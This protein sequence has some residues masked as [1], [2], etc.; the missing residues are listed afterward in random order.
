MI[1]KYLISLLIRLLDSSMIVDYKKINM[2]AFE[3]WAYRSFDDA[4]WKSYFAYEELKILKTLGIPQPD[5]Q[6]WMMIGKRQ[7]L[8]H[9]ADEMRKVVELKKSVEE[10][11]RSEAAK[12]ENAG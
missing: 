6:Y 12:K 1:K 9:L 3:E 5:Y 10:K 7:Q 2:K 4:G 8:L 11:K